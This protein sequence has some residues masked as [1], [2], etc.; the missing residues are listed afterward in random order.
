VAQAPGTS[1]G[2]G[3]KV[4]PPA[5]VEAPRL[6]GALDAVTGADVGDGE[7]L[8]GVRWIGPEGPA[9]TSELEVHGSSLS[10]VRFTGLEL[11]EPTLIDVAVEGCELSGAT[12][13]G[14]RFERVLFKGCRMSGLVASGLRARHVRFEDCQLDGAWLR[15]ASFDRCE[16]VGCD[17]TGADLY[18]ARLIRT[19]VLNCKLERAELSAA[20]LDDVALHGS[21]LDGLQGAGTLGGVIIGADQVMALALPILAAQ[22]VVVDDGYLDTGDPGASGGQ[23]F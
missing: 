3:P 10:G 7:R 6:A 20:E 17:L 1:T 22:G 13:V 18:E 19:K 11:L 9:G 15:S 16:L 2:T 12:L 21:T 5:V 4:E 14:A 23:A 8:E